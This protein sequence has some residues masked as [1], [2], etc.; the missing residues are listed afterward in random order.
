MLKIAR[1]IGFGVILDFS[2][3]LCASVA[4]LS[5]QTGGKAM[6]MRQA[7]TPKIC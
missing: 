5:A 4:P 2:F 6:T 7:I 1:A 3:V